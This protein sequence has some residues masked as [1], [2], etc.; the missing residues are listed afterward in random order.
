MSMQKKLKMRGIIMLLA[1]FALLLAIFS[2]IFPGKVNGLDYM[3]N[4]F[5]MISK[6]SSYFI[7][8]SIKA[9]EQYA[10]KMIDVNIKMENDQQA[11]DTAKLF[12][13]S[14]AEVTVSGNELAVKGDMAGIMKASLEDADQMFHNNGSVL[15]DKYGYGEKQ[16]L[17]NWWTA[18][19]S[20]GKDLT[21]QESFKQAKTITS[22]QSK[23]LEP[24]Y[25]YY[26]VQAGS[27]KDSF[28]L[29][30]AALGFYV[31]YTLWYGF[32]IMYLFE[33]LGLKIGH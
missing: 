32:G 14:G 28:L 26:G 23:A 9:T 8:E 29:I 19:K 27:Y 17:F 24:A 25:N 1:F 12:Q 30:F 33:G 3:D 10:G 21:K 20:M 6:G 22:I 5:N 31:C 16:V 4:M 2:P 15:A 18:F 13:A 7:P 11:T